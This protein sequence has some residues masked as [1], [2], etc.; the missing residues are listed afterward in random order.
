[1]K[2]KYGMQTI[3]I[4]T[5][6]IV[7]KIRW[8][9]PIYL[10]T[11]SMLNNYD[12]ETKRK[13]KKGAYGLY[14]QHTETIK[15]IK[16]TDFLKEIFAIKKISKFFITQEKVKMLYEYKDLDDTT[17]KE[18]INYFFDVNERLIQH[19]LAENSFNFGVNTGILNDMGVIVDF[20]ELAT[21]KEEFI[22]NVINKKWEKQC[23]YRQLSERKK[24]I[25][26]KEAM[27][28]WNIDYINEIWG[29]KKSEKNDA[30][31]GDKNVCR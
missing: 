12:L 30:K 5:K 26:S 31:K 15:K 25:F 23:N 2:I 14:K 10:I 8:A 1:M 11:Y 28:R 22:N 9:Y 6:D 21:S 18:K 20:G 3:N 19:G 29:I 4:I 17:F 13:F 27:K 24:E 16:D 7:Y